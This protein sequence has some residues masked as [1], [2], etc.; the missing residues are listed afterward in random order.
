MPAKTD[1]DPPKEIARLKKELHEREL[2]A[3]EKRFNLLEREIEEIREMA[4][5]HECKHERDFS[6]IEK[7]FAEGKEEFKHIRGRFD[8]LSRIKVWT[9][10]GAATAFIVA[11]L[12]AAYVYGIN[13]T[14]W[15]YTSKKVDVIEITVNKI[16]DRVDSNSIT[17]KQLEAVIDKSLQKHNGNND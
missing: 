15:D 2:A 7:S 1:S 5:E 4:T 6:L 16:R 11:A 8:N 3:Q 10:I 13:K 14:N 17:P 12:G 9:I